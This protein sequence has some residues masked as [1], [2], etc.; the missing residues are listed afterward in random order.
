MTSVADVMDALESR[1]PLDLAE[2]WDVNGL[3]VGRPEAEVTR[4]L[5]AV[6][7]T[8]AVVQEAIDAGCD[9][10]VTHHPLLLRGVS[11]VN[12]GT[13]KGAVIHALIE[14]GIALYNAHTNADAAG[15]GVAEALAEVL[16]VTG[17]LPLVPLHADAEQGTG[18]VGRL[19]TAVTLREFAERAAAVLPRTAH[20]VRVAGDLDGIVRTVAVVGGS[21]DS[22]LAA[23]RAAGADVYLTADLRHHPASDAREAAL[24]GDGRPYLVDVAHYA[25][26]WTW[27]EAA[28]EYLGDAAGIDTIVS[29]LNTDPWTARF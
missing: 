20:G 16:G 4:A 29:T 22:F 11:T 23:A 9:L 3:T 17:G 2:D 15:S 12:A 13:P 24:L 19:D 28:A 21:G 14:H 8:L 5:F 27:L 1:F 6:D 18:R 25:S 26:E 10:I 7:P